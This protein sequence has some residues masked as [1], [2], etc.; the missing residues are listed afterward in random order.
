MDR[1]TTKYVQWRP[2]L[3]MGARCNIA[4]RFGSGAI[5]NSPLGSN[6]TL[7]YAFRKAKEADSA[8]LE[9]LVISSSLSYIS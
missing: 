9:N 2:A 1:I 3:Y 8:S 7:Y 5:N 6:Y 4:T